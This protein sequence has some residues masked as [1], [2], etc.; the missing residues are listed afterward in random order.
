MASIKDIARESGFS[1]TTVSRAL[2]DYYDVSAETKALI[3][4][5]AQRLNY[6]PNIHAKN[7]VMQKSNRIGFVV[8]DFGLAAGEDNFVYE[9]MIGMQK[10]CLDKGFDL[11]FLFGS[12]HTAENTDLAALIQKYDLCGIVIM[13]C[14]KHYKT[15][16]DLLTLEHPV[17]FIDGDIETDYVGSVSVDNFAAA[18]EAVSYLVE[19]KHRQRVLMINGKLDSFASAERLRGYQ[20][21]L[22]KDFD[23]CNVVYGE[24][25]DKLSYRLVEDRMK[26]DGTFP[27]DA[28]FA[29]SDM[30]AVGAQNALLARGYT[31]GKDIDIVG[32]DNIPLSAFIHTPLTTVSQD[33]IRLGEECIHML[34]NI[35]NKDSEN[36]RIIVPHNLVIRNSA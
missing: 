14:G 29:A 18:K 21:V 1:V 17:A 5:V 34:M 33:K 32:F 20:A 36:R 23:A 24:Y 19:K 31:I 13:G 22:G 27:Y 28:I 35:I 26:P 3:R 2:N 8:F 16:R 11:L 10:T 4:E 12:M 25:N 6:S 30:M 15:Y 7:L 9:L